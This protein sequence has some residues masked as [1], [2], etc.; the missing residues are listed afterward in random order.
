MKRSVALLVNA[1][2]TV[3]VCWILMAACAIVYV[4]SHESNDAHILPASEIEEAIDQLDNATFNGNITDNDAHS[5]NETVTDNRPTLNIGVLTPNATDLRYLAFSLAIREFMKMQPFDF[6]FKI[7]SASTYN[8]ATTAAQGAGGFLLPT[9]YGG[10]LADQVVGLAGM[11][12]LL[13]T[14]SAASVAG[15]LSSNTVGC[16]A[17]DDLLADK[18]EFPLLSRVVT[19]N[20]KSGNA[21]A[22]LLKD[23]GW[24]QVVYATSDAD[25]GS[26]TSKSTIENLENHYI[27]VRHVLI[28]NGV[29]SVMQIEEALEDIKKLNLKILIVSMRHPNARK[30]VKCA[31]NV[32]LYGPDYQW[33]LTDALPFDPFFV[34]SDGEVDHKLKT[35]LQGALGLTSMANFAFNGYFPGVKPGSVP[36]SASVPIEV[37]KSDDPASAFRKLMIKSVAWVYHYANATVPA[38]IVTAFDVL[39]A[40]SIFV[41]GHAIQNMINE[42]VLPLANLSTAHYSGAVNQANETWAE[43]LHVYLEKAQFEGVT[44]NI[45]FDKNAERQSKVFLKYVDPDNSSWV[46]FGTFSDESGVVVTKKPI[47]FDRTSNPVWDGLFL[48][49]TEWYQFN[50]G[51][52]SFFLAVACIA[53]ALTSLCLFSVY[54]YKHVKCI[55]TASPLFLGIFGF[56]SIISFMTMVLMYLD[57][58]E[59]VC[60]ATFWFRELGFII[61]F[62]AIVVKTYRISRIF[63]NFRKRAIVGLSD[64]Y[65]LV[66]MTATII[67]CTTVLTLATIFNENFMKTVTWKTELVRNLTVS[68]IP[69]TVYTVYNK[70]DSNGWFYVFAVIDLLF[71]VVG[72]YLAFSVRKVPEAFNEGR[73]ILI[74]VYNWFF[75][76]VVLRV[77]LEFSEINPDVQYALQNVLVL[78]TTGA[79]V[80]VIFTPKF[81]LIYKK[82]G[83][84]V[85]T[86]QRSSIGNKGQL[87]SGERGSEFL[88][89][90]ESSN[91]SPPMSP[92]TTFAHSSE[93]EQV[94]DS[95]EV[96]VKVEAV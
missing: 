2:G 1:F 24:R 16:C 22:G 20:S 23:N 30:F 32:G 64:N 87:S 76:G 43:M 17:S 10:N 49:R 27:L 83:D 36:P 93:M 18:N 39:R 34:D 26:G 96:E 73:Y 94:A 46:P 91:A 5:D 80:A 69:T 41:F 81:W 38:P 56:G 95:T 60:V 66:L 72:V 13:T 8:S 35:V 59:N 11:E 48:Q 9:L 78:F 50:T 51:L 44:G 63:N 15:A 74:A 12:S 29:T 58:S 47:F 55:L 25:F 75:V 88:N 68:D 7:L 3:L 92:Q 37:L 67:V 31:Y 4:D 21:L 52:E 65:L 85:C 90:A 40:D 14:V 62:G 57:Q 6:V 84:K 86:T 45:N 79:A 71:L 19:S 53:I 61:A 82:K 54:F 89:D 77:L 70:C 42:K 28:E 33:I